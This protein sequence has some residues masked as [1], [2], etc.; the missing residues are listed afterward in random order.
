MALGA[1][2]GG[3]LT[4]AFGW[5]AVFWVNVPLSL[6][7]AAAAFA[8]IVKDATHERG[9]G[10]DLGGALTATVGSTALVLAVVQGPE[11]GWTSPA[12][13]LALLTGAASTGVLLSI[14]SRT[15][16]PLMPPA[17]LRNRS[18]AAAMGIT[19]IFMGT[20]GA[21]YYFFTL[22]LQN[23]HA[24]SALAT[25]LAFP[26]AALTGLIGTQASERLLVR[27][28]TRTTI[29]IGLLTGTVGMALLATA[30]SPT[31]GYATLLPGTVLTS[32]GQGIAWTAMFAA[33][34][35]GIEPSYQGIASAMA[36]TTQQIGGAVG[37]AVL[38]AVANAGI[39]VSTGPT[40]VPG[41]R[42][43]GFAAAL[44]TL[45]GAAIALVLPR[46]STTPIASRE[47]DATKP[48]AHT[49]G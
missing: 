39:D 38:A 29:V 3:V 40:L 19:F 41:L 11:A 36:S 21:Q 42:T 31:S 10:F 12:T 7:G 46:R 47:P 20:F 4:S 49:A 14:E 32:L 23:V 43:A 44:L 33:A 28:G 1:L 17:L 45:A 5:E 35:H 18:L 16:H 30:M 13:L 9:R 26:P 8:V 6:G 34:A 22:Y 25:G 15:E 48:A 37:L 24:Y 2:L 27:T